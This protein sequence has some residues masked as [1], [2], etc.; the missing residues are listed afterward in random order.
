MSCQTIVKKTVPRKRCLLENGFHKRN[1]V[2][3]KVTFDPRRWF[4]HSLE[5]EVAEFNILEILLES[6]SGSLPNTS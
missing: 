4:A 6:K 2:Q 3:A 5:R 1:D